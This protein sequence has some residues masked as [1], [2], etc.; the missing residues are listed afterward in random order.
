MKPWQ[1][2]SSLNLQLWLSSTSPGLSWAIGWPCWITWCRTNVWWWLTWTTSTMTSAG[3]RSPS[4]QTN[5]HWG[6]RC[7]ENW[8]TD[9]WRLSW[10]SHSVRV[11]E[12]NLKS[13]LLLSCINKRVRKPIIYTCCV[14]SDVSA[15]VGTATPPPGETGHSCPEPEKQNQPPGHPHCHHWAQYVTHT[16]RCTQPSVSACY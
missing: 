16:H 6:N 1:E 4:L 7:G 12:A 3:W 2:A 14:F 5:K 9:L 11:Y 15:G 13:F 10:S 8:T